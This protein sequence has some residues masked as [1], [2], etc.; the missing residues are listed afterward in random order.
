VETRGY[1]AVKFDPKK[2]ENEMAVLSAELYKNLAEMYELDR[3]KYEKSIKFEKS[4]GKLVAPFA[5]DTGADFFLF[6][7]YRGTEK[8]NDV[9]HMDALIGAATLIAG[10]APEPNM[11]E[12]GVFVL[13]LLDAK[14]GDILWTDIQAAQELPTNYRDYTAK[15]KKPIEETS[16]MRHL[17]EFFPNK[18]I[19]PSS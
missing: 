17:F 15:R 7:R 4:V 3:V 14:T 8:T 19:K 5:Q 11:P 9:R 12:K 16:F 10:F 2:L 6:S 1:K 18:A 13:M